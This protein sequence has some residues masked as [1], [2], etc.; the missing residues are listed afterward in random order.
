MP[1]EFYSNDWDK[2]LENSLKEKCRF[3]VIEG[4]LL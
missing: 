1:L 2:Q 4:I 3:F